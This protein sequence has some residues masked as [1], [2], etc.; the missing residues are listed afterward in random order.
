MIHIEGTRSTVCTICVCG[1]KQT[2]GRATGERGTRG[3][4]SSIM[5]SCCALFSQAEDP[6]DVEH[7]KA[8]D[9][10][11]IK[12]AYCSRA[13]SVFGARHKKVNPPMSAVEL[14][15]GS[16]VIRSHLGFLISKHSSKLWVE[17]TSWL[18]YCTYFCAS[19]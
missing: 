5:F 9:V 19:G 6:A 13:L 14:E 7:L 8:L 16:I 3:E 18:S 11:G 17:L 10:S 15:R 12:K 1:G 4:L 2:L